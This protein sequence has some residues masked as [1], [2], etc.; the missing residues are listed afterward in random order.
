MKMEH[1]IEIGEHN[2]PEEVTINLHEDEEA[3]NIEGEVKKTNWDSILSNIKEHDEKMKGVDFPKK[4]EQSIFENDG[5]NDIEIETD[6]RGKKIWLDDESKERPGSVIIYLIANDELINRKVVSAKEDWEY[7]FTNIPSYDS[8]GNP[9]HY[10]LEEKAVKGYRANVKGY[11]IENLC[12]EKTEATVI[13]HWSNSTKDEELKN[14][15]VS[16]LRNGRKIQE[17]ELS[18]KR[19]WQYTFTGLE[20]YDELGKLYHYQINEPM[21]DTNYGHPAK[22]IL[23]EKDLSNDRRARNTGIALVTG[24][25]LA[26]IGL[27]AQIRNKIKE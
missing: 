26:V 21:Q 17:V 12:V 5:S 3:I 9:I 23:G 7:R 27:V 2:Q 1:G 15:K 16:L 10:R 8:L 13:K 24:T 19:D 20:K 4:D 25:V 6:I 14:I 11:N 18:A 22:L